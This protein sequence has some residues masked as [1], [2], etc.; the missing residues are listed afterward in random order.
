MSDALKDYMD[1][2]NTIKETS[3][4][5]SSLKSRVYYLAKIASVSEDDKSDPIV[6]LA[7]D[8][9]HIDVETYYNPRRNLQHYHRSEQFISEAAKNTISAFK[10]LKSIVDTLKEKFQKTDE[11]KEAYLRN[12]SSNLDKCLRDG[13]DDEEY[14]ESQNSLSSIHYIKEILFNRYR[15]TEEDLEN[16]SDIE[17]KER[18]L[19]KDPELKNF[20]SKP[21]KDSNLSKQEISGS[22]YNEILAKLFS[23]PEVS[24]DL[25]EVSR[26]ITI[27]ITDKVKE[28]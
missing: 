22:S 2:M 14:S 13:I 21:Y 12:L 5:D 27:T 28:D 6:K 3:T 26:T 16:M 7:F 25:K 4:K 23:L 10:K 20:N 1:I 9:R 18:L 19:S 15:L 17:I 8:T 11:W 24:K